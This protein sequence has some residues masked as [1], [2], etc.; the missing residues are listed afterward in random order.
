M[1]PLIGVGVLVIGFGLRANPLG[2]V[3]AAGLASGLASGHSTK[4]TLAVFGKAFNEARYVSLIWLTAPVIGVLERAGLR[5]AAQGLV[6]RARGLTPGRLLIGYLGLRQVTAALGLTALGGQ[7]QM[8][9]PV[10]APMA[11]AAADLSTGG[12]VTD[13][14]RQE[15]KA[16]AAAVDNIGVFF[17]EDIFIAFG[18]VLLIHGVLAAQ[19][20]DVAPGQIARFAMPTAALAFIVHAIRLWRRDRRWRT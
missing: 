7:V 15:I 12:A 3:A 14:T 6:A 18:S 19:G 5:H 11:E 2:V 20:F 16:H 1:T 13:Q 9:R 4:A 17:G 8:V 10:L